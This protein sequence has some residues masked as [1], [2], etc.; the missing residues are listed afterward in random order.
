MSLKE[1]GMFFADVAFVSSVVVRK[2][3]CF[4]SLALI[5]M[6]SRRH[7]VVPSHHF[8]ISTS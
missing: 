1:E 2:A 3:P 8:D 4:Y 6:E 5:F 7:A